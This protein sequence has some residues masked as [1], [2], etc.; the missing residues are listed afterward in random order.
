MTNGW[1]QTQGVAT[2]TGPRDCVDGSLAHHMRYSPQGSK[3]VTGIC[4]RGCGR[5]Q[6]VATA[7]PEG[8]AVNEQGHTV[9]HIGGLGQRPPAGVLD[10]TRWE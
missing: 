9:L 2:T 3:T 10:G 6:T 8:W 1:G 4:T 7:G 5:E